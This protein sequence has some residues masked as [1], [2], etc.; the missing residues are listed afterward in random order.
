MIPKLMKAAIMDGVNQMDVRNIPIPELEDDQ[1]LIRIAYCGI[2]ATDYDNFI[3]ISS[4]TKE[5]KIHFPLRW[6]HEW[7]GRV[8][9]VG[10]NVTKFKVGDRVTSESKVTCGN[11]EACK[12]GKWYDCVNKRS[13][14]TVGNTWPGGMAEYTVLPER[15]TIPI[16]ENVSFQQA[17]A[18]EAA[19]IAMNGLRDLPLQDSCVLIMGSGPIGL[20]AISLAHAMGA[21]TVI[22]AARKKA[23]LDI[24]AQMG[25]D[26]IINTTETNLYEELARITKGQLAD[27]VLETSGE[28]SF[29]ENMI[30]LVR[31]GGSFSTV[32]FYNRYISGFNMDDVV[33]NKINI[34][35]RIGSHNCTGPLLEMLNDGRVN[36]DPVITSVIDFYEHAADCMDC[37]AVAKDSGAK[38]LVKVFGE[39]A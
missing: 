30:K 8:C 7:S 16:C 19:S 26:F 39:D 12:N 27:I 29:V 31:T 22:I 28:A 23:K 4:F 33:F 2:C 32:S 10:K 35:G 5:G 14:G 3:G 9:A 25:A 37:Y 20:S 36:I 15:N 24:A 11:C 17:A 21:K 18:L 13:I 1:L 6:G 38:M 34:Y